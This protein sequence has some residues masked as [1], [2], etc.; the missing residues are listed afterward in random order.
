MANMVITI[1]SEA[2]TINA[3][4]DGVDIGPVSSI[5]AYTDP[6]MEYFYVDVVQFEKG[7]NKVSKT[8]RYSASGSE[9]FKGEAVSAAKEAFKKGG[10]Q[11]SAAFD[12]MFSEKS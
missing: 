4:I 2:Q 9:K 8:T 11:V 3:I 1:D 7:D 5:G 10:E 6:R 12:K